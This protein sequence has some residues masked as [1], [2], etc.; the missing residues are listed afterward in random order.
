M[1][2]DMSGGAAVLGAMKAIGKLK[3]PVSVIGIIPTAENFPDAEA[4]RPGDIFIARNGKSVMV[5]NTDAEGRLIL[6]DGLDQAG[7]EG[8]THIV[9]IATLTG[10]C[11]GALGSSIAGIMGNSEQLI[12]AVIESG[13]NHGEEFWQLPLPAEYKKWL[14][15]PHADINN[16]G[17]RLAGASTAGLFLQEFVPKNASWVHLDIAGP[18]F[19]EKAWKYYDAGGIGFGTKALIDLA[20]RFNDYFNET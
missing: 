18:A 20:E 14:M 10:A 3:P 4:Q 16:I 8:A 6:I 2:S 11:V 7:Q 1:K 12:Q 19:Q 15:T 17:G 5:D 13:Q 9:D